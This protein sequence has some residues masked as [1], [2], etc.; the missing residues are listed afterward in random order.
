M[1]S[2]KST[3]YGSGQRSGVIKI[4]E[5]FFAVILGALAVYLIFP[6]F[7]GTK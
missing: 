1:G 7:R 5:Y 3:F 2:E 4:A 6:F